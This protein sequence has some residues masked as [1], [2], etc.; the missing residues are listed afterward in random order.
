MSN[1][2]DGMDLLVLGLAPKIFCCACEPNVRDISSSYIQGL[3]RLVLIQK[4]IPP[5]LGSKSFPIKPRARVT[6]QAHTPWTKGNTCS[7]GTH[8][9]VTEQGRHIEA[10]LVGRPLQFFFPCALVRRRRGTGSAERTAT[11]SD[12]RA[13]GSQASVFCS[14]RNQKKKKIKS[15]AAAVRGREWGKKDGGVRRTGVESIGASSSSLLQLINIYK[16]DK[17]RSWLDLKNPGACVS[18]KETGEIFFGGVKARGFCVLLACL[19]ALFF[20]SVSC[21]AFRPFCWFSPLIA[22]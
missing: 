17:A 7:R 1:V 4:I 9:S 6:P 2:D 16:Q 11:E 3:M 14:S 12:E 10:P 19:A 21:S 20:P 15:S 5:R 18:T 13:L 8:L 22:D